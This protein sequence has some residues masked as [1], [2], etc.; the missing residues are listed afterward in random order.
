MDRQMGYCTRIAA[1][2]GQR[3]EE[4]SDEEVRV[5]LYRMRDNWLRVTNGL[6]ARS[7]AAML[8]AGPPASRASRIGISIFASTETGC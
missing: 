8:G 3:A 4:S 6:Q 1:Q 7:T 2:C 5:F